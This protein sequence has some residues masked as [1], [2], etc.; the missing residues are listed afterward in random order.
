MQVVIEKQ[1]MLAH[2]VVQCALASMTEWRMPDVVHQSKGLDQINVQSQLCC[3]CAGN[4]GDF[5]S[6]RQAIAEM[7]GISARK[8]LGL[9][10]QAPKSSRMNDA[11]AITLKIVTVRVRRLR[12]AAASRV[13]HGIRSQHYLSLAEKQLAVSIWHSA[14]TSYLFS[15]WA[16]VTFADSSFFWILAS[17]S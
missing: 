4:L 1:P 3:N 7:I 5:K 15:C 11:V 2:G 10:F 6:V 17:A 9:R 13:L 16:N 12:V 8:Y 14:S